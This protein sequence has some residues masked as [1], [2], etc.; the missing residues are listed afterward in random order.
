MTSLPV[1]GEGQYFDCR[2]VFFGRGG[3]LMRGIKI[4]QYEFALKMRGGGG[5]LCAR[6]AYLR[7][8]T[9]INFGHSMS[10]IERFIPTV[11]VNLFFIF[12]SVSEICLFIFMLFILFSH[13]TI[14]ICST[15]LSFSLL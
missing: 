2:M 13:G 8:T 14:Y 6:G 12:I 5:G 1:G 7:D 4:P 11:E 10:V 3:E 15:N 9:V